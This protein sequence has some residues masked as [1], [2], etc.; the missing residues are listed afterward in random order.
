MFP[1]GGNIFAPLVLRRSEADGF[2][3]E[4]ELHPEDPVFEGHFPHARVYP[5]ALLLECMEKAVRVFCARRLGRVL[6]LAEV[7]SVRFTA[8]LVPGDRVVIEGRVGSD[9]ADHR[10]RVVISRAGAQVA[11]GRLVFRE[12]A[13]A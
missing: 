5:G 4:L 2:A 3:F 6:A 7:Q 10:S 9:G 13:R 11:E 1:V 12:V 8:P